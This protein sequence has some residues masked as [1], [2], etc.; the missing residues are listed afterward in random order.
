MRN[1]E[2][3][4]RMTELINKIWHKFPD[5][6]FWQIINIL[7]FPEELRGNDLFYVEDDIWEDIF[8][9]TLKKIEESRGANDGN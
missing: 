6:R 1:P 5:M 2:R 9:N 3:I 7:E 4:N 8:K